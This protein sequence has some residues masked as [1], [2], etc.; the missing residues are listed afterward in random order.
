MPAPDWA[1]KM[2]HIVKSQIINSFTLFRDAIP[3]LTPPEE[4]NTGRITEP[5][6]RPVRE[7]RS[8]EYLK[9]YEV[10][11]LCLVEEWV[12]RHFIEHFN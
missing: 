5:Q 12:E 1:Q 6:G 11:E 3:V 7:R 8:P 2:L 9:E 4:D 10:Y